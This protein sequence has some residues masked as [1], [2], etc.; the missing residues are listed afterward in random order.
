MTH[1]PK[2]RPVHLQRC[3]PDRKRSPDII[4]RCAEYT[5]REAAAY[6]REHHGRFHAVDG[7]LVD[8]NEVGHNNNPLGLH[9]TMTL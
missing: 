6:E 1:P 8:V 9:L 4:N 5:E 7:L 3:L 2:V